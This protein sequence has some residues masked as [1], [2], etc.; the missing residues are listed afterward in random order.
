MQRLE[1][2]RWSVLR[3]VLNTT[4]SGLLY[5]CCSE[6]FRKSKEKYVKSPYSVL[7]LYYNN[8]LRHRCL[9]CTFPIFAFH[10]QFACAHLI[11]AMSISNN[12]WNDLLNA[13]EIK[14][15]LHQNNCTI[16]ILGTDKIFFSAHLFCSLRWG[17]AFFKQSQIPSN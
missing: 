5:S 4:L 15:V 8:S 13:I 10:F 9:P 14:Q 1:H 3:M 6:T 17:Q 11:L 2:L 16:I 7:K 12:I